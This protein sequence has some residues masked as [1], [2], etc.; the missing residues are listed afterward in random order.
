[1]KNKNG[2]SKLDQL[3]NYGWVKLSWRSRTENMPCGRHYV[4]RVLIRAVYEFPAQAVS[5]EV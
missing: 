4:P 1:M 3:A 2:T 5:L